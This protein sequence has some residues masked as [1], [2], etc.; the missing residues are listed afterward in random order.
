ECRCS[1]SIAS[2]EF[3]APSR[4]RRSRPCC[5]R[6]GTRPG[7]SRAVSA[8]VPGGRPPGPAQSAGVPGG[9]PPGPAQSGS[10]LGMTSDLAEPPPWFTKALAAPVV[11]RAVSVAGT[12]IA[13][14]QF[15]PDRSSGTNGSSALVLVHGGAA[16]AR[17]WDHIAPLL[18]T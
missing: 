16:H 10:L 3:P 9:R 7:P 11:P 12:E 5:S 1:S 6:P 8:G 13:Y 2:T 14:R 4:P 17:W 15:G 18:A